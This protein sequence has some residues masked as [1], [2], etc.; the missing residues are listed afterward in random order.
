[1]SRIRPARRGSS[2]RSSCAGAR[3]SRPGTLS[4]LCCGRVSPRRVPT[5]R[6]RERER[7]RLLETAGRRAGAAAAHGQS[8]RGTSSVQGADRG[9]G[10]APRGAARAGCLGAGAAGGPARRAGSWGMLGGVGPGTRIRTSGARLTCEPSGSSAPGGACWAEAGARG[11]RRGRRPRTSRSSGTSWQ[12]LLP[13]LRRPCPEYGDHCWAAA[14]AHAGRGARGTA[15][16]GEMRRRSCLPARVR[17]PLERA[18]RV[19]GM[20]LRML[21]SAGS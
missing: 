13:G 9:E 8:D 20:L 19:I 17:L 18:A 10:A 1:M 6:R 21:V 2:V 4:A 16:C 12:Q 7:R 14:G 11:D 5:G 3:Q 15:C